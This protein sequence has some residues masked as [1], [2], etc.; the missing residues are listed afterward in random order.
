MATKTKF[1]KDLFNIDKLIEFRHWM[2]KNAELSLVEFNTH[3][4]IKE[5]LIDTIGI[6]ES[7]IETTVNTGLVVTLQGTAEPRGEKFCVALRADIDALPIQENNPELEYQ[8]TSGVAH[9]CGHD[10]H[11][12]CLLGGASIIYNNLDLLPSN[13]TAKLLFQPGEEG[14]R[15]ALKMIEEGCMKDVDE[16]Y[17]MHNFPQKGEAEIM[18]NDREMMA[19]INFFKMKVNFNAL[20]GKISNCHHLKQIL[21]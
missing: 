7:C 4:K 12:A 19:T 15:G 10:G 8:S 21:S 2:H 3:A 6:P 16:V 20:I 13:K 11:T 14:H 5:Y 17:G 9:M 1:K 18:V